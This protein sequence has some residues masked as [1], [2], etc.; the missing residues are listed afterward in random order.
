MYTFRN[1]C[2]EQ[3]GI[4]LNDEATKIFLNSKRRQRGPRPGRA[5]VFCG[6]S[7]ARRPK[8]YLYKK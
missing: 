2:V 5:G 6:T 1:R 7:T 4:E 3:D 8:G